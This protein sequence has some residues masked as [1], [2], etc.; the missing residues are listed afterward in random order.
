MWRRL[1]ESRYDLVHAHFGWSGLI[2]RCQAAAPVVVSF[3]GDD[4]LGRFKRNGR[5]T[6]S[7][8]FLRLTSFVLARSVSAVIVKSHQ[9]KVALRMDSAYVIPNG[10]DIDLFRPIDQSEARRALGLDLNKKFVLFP[11]DPAIENKRHDLIAAAVDLAREQEPQLEMLYVRGAPRSRMPLYLN[12][13]DVF[14]LASHSE[15]SPNAVKE[16]MAVNLPIVTVDVGDAAALIG[17]AESCFLVPREVRAI[18]S[19]IVEV[20]RRG[21][22]SRGREWIVPLSSENVAKQIME[23]YASVLGRR[24]PSQQE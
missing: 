10:V 18:A 11:F 12:A 6:A 8:H 17:S 2:A 19:R 20:C 1:G 7:S 9:M 14:V 24:A 4:V 22:R 23:V 5:I 16:A 15:G 21:E 13:A 3:M